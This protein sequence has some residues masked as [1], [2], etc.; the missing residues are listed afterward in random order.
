VIPWGHGLQVLTSATLLIYINTTSP[1][2]V[3]FVPLVMLLTSANT[4]IVG[5]STARYISLFDAR[6][7]TASAVSGVIQFTAVGLISIGISAVHDGT[8]RTMAIGVVVC[9]LAASLCTAAITIAERSAS[10]KEPTHSG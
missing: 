1:S 9:S 4:F 2:L 7:G 8:P 3:V 6:R 10:G 5:N